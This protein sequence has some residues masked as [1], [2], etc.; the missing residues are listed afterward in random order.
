MATAT[1]C[2][3]SPDRF[4]DGLTTLLGIT[5]DRRASLRRSLGPTTLASVR[6]RTVINIGCGIRHGSL[7]VP[8]KRRRLRARRRHG[9]RATFAAARRDLAAVPTPGRKAT[10]AQARSGRSTAAF[11]QRS[12]SSASCTT[13]PSRTGAPAADKVAAS[14]RAGRCRALVLRGGRAT[15]AA[16]LQ[17]DRDD[18]APIGS[19]LQLNVC[20]QHHQGR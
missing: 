16:C 19:R 3:G 11:D 20:A 15:A 6:R 10:G 1:T 9:R 14:R 18:S 8:W 13:S 7:L 17:L 12:L 2:Q 4:G 5:A